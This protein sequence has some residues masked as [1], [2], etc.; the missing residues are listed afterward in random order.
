[1][2]EEK[3]INVRIGEE[4]IEEDSTCL[5]TTNKSLTEEAE[6]T[7]I[8]VEQNSINNTVSEKEISDNEN[9]PND[10]SQCDGVNDDDNNKNTIKSEEIIISQTNC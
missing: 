6:A 1:M 9:V 8:H 5:N 3:T 7:K 10:I 2:D 4:E